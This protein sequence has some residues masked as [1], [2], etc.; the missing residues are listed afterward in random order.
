MREALS[1]ER[2]ET[3]IHHATCRVL[4]SKLRYQA[5]TD[6]DFPVL[7]D[8]PCGD[9]DKIHSTKIRK[10]G[11]FRI[12]VGRLECASVQGHEC[13]E[14]PGAGAE[15]QDSGSARGRPAIQSQQQTGHRGGY[16][17]QTRVLASVMCQ[18]T[19]RDGAGDCQRLSE[20]QPQ[21]VAADCVE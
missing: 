11:Q 18:I 13:F 17:A 4:Q 8:L 5:V 7:D 9:P 1:S 21:P 2:S 12:A 10:T 16:A 14:H 3:Y 19:S 15:T 20:S 6:H